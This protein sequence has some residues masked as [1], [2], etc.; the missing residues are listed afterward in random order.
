MK[1]PGL[2]GVDGLAA[3]AAG[4]VEH[5]QMGQA[6]AARCPGGEDGLRHDHRI[7]PR[8]VVGRV[9]KV[10]KLADRGVAGLQHLDVDLG[11]DRLQLV[12]AD[13]GQ[14]AVH[15]L[16]PGPERRL[17]RC[18]LLA[19]AG[20]RPLEGVA[21]QIGHARQHQSRQ[22]LG[23]AHRST[24]LDPGE[25]A[26]GIDLQ[27]DRLGH[28]VRQQGPFGPEHAHL[29]SH[30]VVTGASRMG[31]RAGLGK[32]ARGANATMASATA[33]GAGVVLQDDKRMSSL[34]IHGKP[35][36]LARILGKDGPATEGQGRHTRSARRRIGLE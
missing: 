35:L 13:L 34:H 22:R 36:E 30:R 29:S 6:D 8:P 7:G 3:E 5:R 14:G 1:E 2:A 15:Q 21:V 4:Q 10:M 19:A 20:E 27:P 23:A 28:A 12:R 11:G 9:V 33:A 32:G 16:A 26:V 17:A 24:R 18:Q 25:V 31:R